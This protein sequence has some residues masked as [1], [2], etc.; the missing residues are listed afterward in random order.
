[1]VVAGEASEQADA[2]GSG[3]LGKGDGDLPAWIPEVDSSESDDEWRTLWVLDVGR[4]RRP[5]LLA[6]WSQRLGGDLARRR[7]RRGGRVRG[8]V[9]GGLVRLR[10]G[11]RRPRGRPGARGP[12][13]PG[14]ARL[15]RRSGRRGR[16]SRFCRGSPATAT[17]SRATCCSSTRRPAPSTTV[18]TAG[19]DV[20][21]ATWRPDGSILAAGMRGFDAV[22]LEVTA[23]AWRRRRTRH[24]SASA[25]S[26]PG[27][28]PLGR[29]VRGGMSSSSR[30]PAVVRVDGGVVD[31]LIDGRH[32]GQDTAAGRRG[33]ATRSS[34]GPRR[35]G[36]RSRG[37]WRRRPGQGRTRVL[38]NVHGGPIW[39]FK[40]D[41][42]LL[43][44][45]AAPLAR[46]RDPLPE[47][48]RLDGPRA[49]VRAGGRR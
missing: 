37:G 25:S 41:W 49:G 20:T 2:L 42:L 28:Q 21:S 24:A 6:P 34:P 44:E 32:P 9:G 36:R 5:P 3:S 14:P 33:A 40:D 48:A 45:H 18:D 47:P 15:R 35:T 46:L 1:M 38:L 10:P 8:S 39:Q 19:V 4:R 11:R 23:R 17:W 7:P 29:G 13:Q 26:S 12:A 16:R 43:Y 30:P 22:V 27:S 31:V